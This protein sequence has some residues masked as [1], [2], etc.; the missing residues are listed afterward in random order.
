[1]NLDALATNNTFLTV[2]IGDFSAKLRN[3][4]LKRI[5]SF[6]GSQME[7][8]DSQFARSQ[9]IKEP[10]PFLDNSKFCINL[11]FTSQPNV[12]MHSGV[13]PSLLSNCHH[14]IIYVKVDLKVF[15]HPPYE[16]TV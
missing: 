9:V 8:L 7:F 14:Q 5:T 1:M 13:N 6:E 11:I 12:I 3:W 10:T 16:K 2:M 4:Y 15:Y